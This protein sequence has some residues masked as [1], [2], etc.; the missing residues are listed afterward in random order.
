VTA[1]FTVTLSQAST[2]AVTVTY[3]TANG[4]AVAGTDYVAA[5]GVLTFNPGQTSQTI[6]VTVLGNSAPGSDNRSCSN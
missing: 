4:T 5:S 6:N 3:A 1:S 2:K